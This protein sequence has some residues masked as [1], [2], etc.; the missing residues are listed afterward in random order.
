MI[1]E[2]LED[3]AVARRGRPIASGRR[4]RRGAAAA[5]LVARQRR[6]AR[7]RD[8]S[9]SVTAARAPPVL[10]GA[11]PG[12]DRRARAAARA[13]AAD[14]RRPPRSRGAGPAAGQRPRRGVGRAGRGGCRTPPRSSATAGTG[15]ARRAR[16]TA[17][18]R[19]SCRCSASTSGRTP[20]PST[21][22]ARASPSTRTGSRRVLARPG[23]DVIDGLG[24]AV[25]RVLAEPSHRSEAAADRRAMR[26]L[27]PAD[28]ALDLL[29]RRS[30]SAARRAPARSPRAARSAATSLASTGRAR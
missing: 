30:A 6:S 4:A 20:P 16:R 29:A 3:P 8:A 19:S 10:P 21:A 7:L 25:E 15:H 26:A 24:P 5:R 1:P 17:C 14:D 28:A 18:R 23:P 2:P 11:L 9:G 12:G 22:P 13:R 27:P